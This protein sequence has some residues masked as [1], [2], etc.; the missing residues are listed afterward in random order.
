MRSEFS[1]RT[2]LEAWRKANGHCERCKKKIVAGDGPEYDHRLP[3]RIGGGN[4]IENCQVLCKACHCWKTRDDTPAICKTR[5]LEKQ[6]AK[7]KRKSRPMMGTK[8]SGWKKRLN[9]EAVRR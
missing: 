8:A 9:G 4:D 6:A 7:A 2:K 1:Q 3:D 5:S